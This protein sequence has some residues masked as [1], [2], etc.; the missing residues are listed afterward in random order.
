MTS[1]LVIGA[2]GL[3]CPA[4]LALAP[5]AGLRLTIVDDDRVDE[6]NLQRQILHRSAD[7][8]RLKVESAR[9]ALWRRWPGAQLELVAARLDADNA[10][11]LV[12]AHDVVLDGSDSFATK[13]LL[14]DVC[15]SS[16]VPL[17]HGGVVGLAGQLMTVL[18]G[19]ACFRCIFEAPPEA[20]AVGSCREAGILGAVA[21]VVGGRMAKEAL[22]I[23]DGRPLLAGTLLRFDAR[24]GWRSSTPR[25]RPSC[26]AHATQ[27]G[28]TW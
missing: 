17:V 5:T 4:L 21:G 1:A 24:T 22:A 12:T 23:L 11:S 26:P 14:N 18:D 20:G 16:G 6:S 2:G 19:H 15:L 28:A 10:A 8:G 27:A 9:D 13:F 3:G 25:Q 7:V